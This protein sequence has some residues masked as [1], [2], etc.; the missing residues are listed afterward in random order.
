MKS[1]IGSTSSGQSISI[2]VTKLVEF[3]LL[4]QANSGGGKS[5]AIWRI[6]EQTHGAIQQIVIDLKDDF[7]TFRAPLDQRNPIRPG[8][9]R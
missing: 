4:I 2:D 3:R 9:A 6:L 1:T 5:W 8:S 7:H